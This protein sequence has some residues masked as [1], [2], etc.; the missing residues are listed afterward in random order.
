MSIRALTI[1]ERTALHDGY[2]VA[3]TL[4]C[5][6][7]IGDGICAG[8]TA[9]HYDSIRCAQGHAIFVKL[10]DEN[11]DEEDEGWNSLDTI[12]RTRLSS[13]ASRRLSKESPQSWNTK[14]QV[15]RLH[16]AKPKCSPHISS[17]PSPL[18]RKTSDLERLSHQLEAHRYAVHRVDWDH[19][20]NAHRPW[21]DVKA[22]QQ[23]CGFCHALERRIE[24]IRK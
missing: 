13:S 1:S 12:S 22:R 7:D 23:R 20:D 10:E 6:G 9:W 8:K 3:V 5:A 15:A 16:S 4:T 18:T 17:D 11:S 24:E 19:F 14:P 2:G 21:M